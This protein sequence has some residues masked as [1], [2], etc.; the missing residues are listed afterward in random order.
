MLQQRNQHGRED[1]GGA[2][3]QGD[4]QC[5]GPSGNELGPFTQQQEGLATGPGEPGKGGGGVRAG[6]V[7]QGYGRGFYSPCWGDGG[8]GSMHAENALVQALTSEKDGK[9][10]GVGEVPAA[11]GPAARAPASRQAW[12]CSPP[13]SCWESWRSW[14]HR[15]GQAA[16]F[17]P[18]CILPHRPGC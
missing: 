18:R 8:L 5:Q 4:S 9:A 7:D 14:E 17:L 10:G 15:P 3:E 13:Q 1:G 2:S 12:L 16:L 6:W 11:E